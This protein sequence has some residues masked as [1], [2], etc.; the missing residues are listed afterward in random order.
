MFLHDT[1][2][3]FI[4]LGLFICCDLPFLYINDYFK[5]LPP[6]FFP[7]INQSDLLNVDQYPYPT[8]ARLNPVKTYSFL[9][10]AHP[11]K[12]AVVDLRHADAF[13]SSHILLDF[14][15]DAENVTI[16]NLPIEDY[17]SSPTNPFL[18]GP[19]LVK[20]Y[21]MLEQLLGG[22]SLPFKLADKDV[23]FVDSIGT[24]SS[25]ACAVIVGRHVGTTKAW[26][27]EDGMLGWEKSALPRT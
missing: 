26:Y 18:D 8:I 22:D 14:V 19:T 1:D 27:I 4:P 15:K 20:Q 9:K 5:K 17:A 6:S 10:G 21:K 12:V 24:I 3:S 23:V 11:R 7:K 13:A 2:L 25:T 16:H